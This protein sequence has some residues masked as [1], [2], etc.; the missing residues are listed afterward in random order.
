MNAKLV[1]LFGF[2]AIP[3]GVNAQW[4]VFD[5]AVQTQLITGTAQEIAKYVEMINN[6]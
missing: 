5:A 6:R 2:T 4:A 1:A 3:F